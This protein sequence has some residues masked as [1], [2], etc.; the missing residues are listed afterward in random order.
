MYV[1]HSKTNF[2]FECECI[3]L[4]FEKKFDFVFNSFFLSKHCE[5]ILDVFNL[6]LAKKQADVEV[7]H[8]FI[9]VFISRLIDL[10]F[11]SQL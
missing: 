7:S 5:E 1:S 11:K 3:G 2:F 4:K 10:I 9:C 6:V 8:S